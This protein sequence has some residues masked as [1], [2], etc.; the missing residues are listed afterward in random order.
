MSITIY[1]TASCEACHAL[2]QWLS[3]LRF[4][5]NQ[6][7]IDQDS[8]SMAEYKNINDGMVSLPFTV[9]VDDAGVETRISGFSKLLYSKVLKV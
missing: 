4:K 9:V 3:E 8:E 6:K 2:T 7:I 5:Y 1:T